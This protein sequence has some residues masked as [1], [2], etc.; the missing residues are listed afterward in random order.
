MDLLIRWD[1]ARV[2]NQIVNVVRPHRPWVSQIIHLNGGRAIGKNSSALA[3]SEALEI[4]RDIDLQVS[5][6]LGDFEVC[7]G[8][9]VDELGEGVGDPLGHRI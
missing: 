4:H 5:G 8:S 1:E 6:Q 9:N 2:G 7:F 3:L